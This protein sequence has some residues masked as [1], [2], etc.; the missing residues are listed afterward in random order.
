M[1]I[2]AILLLTALYFLPYFNARIRRTRNSGAVGVVN[3]FL[4][5]TFIGWVVALAMSSSGVIEPK[6]FLVPGA[7]G[8][9]NS[10]FVCARC[11][12]LGHGSTTVLEK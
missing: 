9:I 2:V 8:S 7:N 11:G 3:L 1:S 12:D 5:W 10:R 4:G 6:K